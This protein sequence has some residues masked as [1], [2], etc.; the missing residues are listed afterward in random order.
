MKVDNVRK[1]IL[2]RIA[3]PIVDQSANIVTDANSHTR[4]WISTFTATTH[5]ITARRTCAGSSSTRTSLSRTTA[6]LKR[7]MIS[8]FHHVSDKHL[9]RYVAEFDRRWNTRKTTDGERAVWSFVHAKRPRHPQRSDG[10]FV[11]REPVVRVLHRQIGFVTH[12][13]SQAG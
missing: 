2:Q 1:G 4:G 6:L 13:P 10:P 3:K 7:G 12:P 11:L 8:T 5:W 9:P